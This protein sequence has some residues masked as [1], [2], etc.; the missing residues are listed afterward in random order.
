MV[1]MARRPLRALCASLILSFLSIKR[2]VG[3][4]PSL[5]RAC[6]RFA[7]PAT[8]ALCASLI[9]SFLI[10]LPVFAD[11]NVP[12]RLLQTGVSKGDAMSRA[13]LQERASEISLAAPVQ[14]IPAIPTLQ[15]AA[16]QEQSQTPNLAAEQSANTIES[17]LAQ[18][19]KM[20]EYNV[21]W[22]SWLA[23]VADRWY[24][25]LQ[26]CEQATGSTFV[27]IR[28]ALIQF[29]CYSNGTIGNVMLKQSSG[30]PVYDRVQMV[31]LMQ[32]MPVPPFPY[33]THRQT[34]TLVQG[35]ESHYRRPGESDYIPGSFGK[36]FPMEKVKEWVR[37]R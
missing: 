6:W 36:G 33:G 23:K 35:W 15:A 17:D 20:R 24:F 22:S 14:A 3:C 37:L 12:T 7:S 2:S 10:T 26:L 5:L 4:V 31:A 1:A 11:Q 25:M 8:S 18:D 9:L 32:S 13:E 27:T 16:Q 34:I 30:S 19:V 28:P 29:T 21:D